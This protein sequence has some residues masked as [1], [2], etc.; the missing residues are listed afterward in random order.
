MSDFKLHIH[1]HTYTVVCNFRLICAH[2]QF[3]CSGRQFFTTCDYDWFHTSV[4]LVDIFSSSHFYCCRLSSHIFTRFLQMQTRN[5]VTFFISSRY[6]FLKCMRSNN[7]SSVS[8]HSASTLIY[9]YF[10]GIKCHQ[11]REEWMTE[12]M[13]EEAENK[14]K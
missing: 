8:H 13:N 4:T 7:A 14:I 9:I 10:F 5:E 11:F 3:L 1:T 6:I 2:T 12:W